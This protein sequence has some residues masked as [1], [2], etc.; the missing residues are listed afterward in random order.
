MP[1]RDSATSP[2]KMLLR[3]NELGD[4]ARPGLLVDLRGSRDLFE[5]P[6]VHHRDTIRHDEASPWLWTRG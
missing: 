6:C 4:E 1:L 3:A 2:S 5:S